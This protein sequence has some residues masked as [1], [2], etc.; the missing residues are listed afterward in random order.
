M[1]DLKHITESELYAF[2]HEL[3][4]QE[5]KESF[6]SHICTCNYCSDLFAEAMSE[7]MIT[8]PRN[9]KDNLLKAAKRPEVQLAVKARETSKQ[10]QLFLYS[11]KVGSA[12]VL[13]LLLL[14]LT[15]NFNGTVPLHS[16][17]IPNPTVGHEVSDPD[18]SEPD[19]P[20]LPTRIRDNMN[21]IS[22]NILDFSNNIMKNGGK[23][24]D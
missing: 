17:S 15:V 5:E 21:K 22:S 3:M 7:E 20:S 11:L 2:R 12:T 6:L 19:T 9:M 23:N 13:A 10:M 18:V 8:A 4:S 14:L 16:S 24:N 1:N